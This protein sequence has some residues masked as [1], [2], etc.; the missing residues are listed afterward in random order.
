ME[1]VKCICMYSSLLLY[2]ACE[3]KTK[4]EQYIQSTIKLRVLKI[5]KTI[6]YT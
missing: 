1:I 5:S 2:Y 4:K 3:K 6:A